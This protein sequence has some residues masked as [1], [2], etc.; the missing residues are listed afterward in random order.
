MEIHPLL[1]QFGGSLVAILALA[2]LARSLKLGG[3][4]ALRDED[5]VREAAGEVE[6]GFD[7][8]RVSIARGGHAALARDREGRIMLIKLHGNRYAGRILTGAARV[9]EKVDS[10]EIDCGE[11]RYGKVSLALEDA[12]YWADAINRL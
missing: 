9:Q 12:G 7:A 6:D 5:Q 10:L 3:T 1:L 11:A 4:P 2:F 8:T